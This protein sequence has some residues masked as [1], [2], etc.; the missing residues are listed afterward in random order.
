M[1]ELLLVNSTSW[2]F[3]DDTQHDTTWR[4]SAVFAD[5]CCKIKYN[6][7]CFLMGCS[8]SGLG[9]SC[10]RF[11]S[12]VACQRDILLR[13]AKFWCRWNAFSSGGKKCV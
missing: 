11:T 6:G 10:R 7:V 13:L 4:R 8:S 3:P 2:H 1:L 9:F 5:E 12:V